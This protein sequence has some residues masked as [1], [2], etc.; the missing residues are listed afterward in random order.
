[1]SINFNEPEIPGYAPLT[2]KRVL[3]TLKVYGFIEVGDIFSF[4]NFVCQTDSGTSLDISEIAYIRKKLEI[5]LNN[6]DNESNYFIPLREFAIELDCLIEIHH[7]H[8]E[9]YSH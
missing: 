4:I 1:M 8:K 5:C 7:H 6:N 9:E 3:D 2:C